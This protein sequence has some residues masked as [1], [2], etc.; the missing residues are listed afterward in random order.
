MPEPPSRPWKPGTGPFYG[1]TP[2]RRNGSASSTV[3]NNV[4]GWGN[5]DL[6]YRLANAGYEVVLCPVTNLYFDLAA[7]PDPEE[8]G[9]RWGGFLDV[10][11]P[12]D[13][14]PLDY[15]RSTR[16]DHLGQPLDPKVF[17]GKVRLTTA[18]RGRIIGLQGCLWS[19]TLTEAGR[20][21]HMLVPKL[22][23]L[24][25]RAWA[26]DPAWATETDAVRAVS[27]H[28]EDWSRFLN[29]YSGFDGPGSLP[30][31][32]R[33]MRPGGQDVLV[34]LRSPRGASGSCPLA[35]VR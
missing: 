1:R 35:R 28:H 3:W 5:E 14:I 11:K 19:E 2:R 7:T 32:E 4:P 29:E 8:V 23:G 17:D 24:A 16:Q 26:P 22:L 18:G 9:L 31:K 12:F 10:D 27:L 21:D 13:F 33:R 34:T 20:L 25:E 15:Y 30:S 6:A